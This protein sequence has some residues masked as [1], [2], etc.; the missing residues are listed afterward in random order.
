MARTTIHVG[1]MTCAHCNMA[2]ERAL[3]EIDGVTA[4]TADFETGSV[5]VDADGP[6]DE[7]AAR[8][9]IAE[10]G[11]EVLSIDSVPA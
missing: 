1:G 6:L 11:Y 2:I 7:P 4:V 9:A 10:E 3:T 8:N 5:L